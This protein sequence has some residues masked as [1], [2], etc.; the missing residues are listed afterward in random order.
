[1]SERTLESF[2]TLRSPSFEVQQAAI[3]AG[4]TSVRDWMLDQ[5][6]AEI[7]LLKQRVDGLEQETAPLEVVD[8]EG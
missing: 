8:A 7:R 6:I 2:P 4:Y 5:C 1:M 3:A